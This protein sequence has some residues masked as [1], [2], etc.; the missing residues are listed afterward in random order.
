MHLLNTFQLATNLRDAINNWNM[1]TNQWLRMIVYERVPK[2]Y[3]TFLT[4]GL[5]ALWH[6]FYAGYYLT[7]TSGALVVTA[8]RSVRLQISCFYCYFFL[9]REIID[10]ILT[11]CHSFRQEKCS[12]IDSSKANIRVYFM[13][14]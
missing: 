7:F 6:G 13:I 12:A 9:C 8:A 10:S 5:S 11:I 14:F 3:G 4:F 2:K 1:G